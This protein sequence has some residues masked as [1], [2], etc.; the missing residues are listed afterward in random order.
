MAYNSAMKLMLI[1]RAGTIVFIMGCSIIVDQGIPKE[2]FSGFFILPLVIIIVGYFVIA[3][4]LNLQIINPNKIQ[5][6]Y[7]LVYVL[8]LIALSGP[9]IIAAER[10]SYKVTLS[11][12]GFL[13]NT[14]VTILSIYIIEENIA[15][16]VDDRDEKKLRQIECSIMT[17]R[18]YAT[19]IILIVM[20]YIKLDINF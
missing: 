14:I 7:L 3:L 20:V 15:K 18:F 19:L 2:K 6:I 4:R 16:Y 11:N 1:N 12:T 8:N 10:Q 9:Y 5:V 13:I 17:S